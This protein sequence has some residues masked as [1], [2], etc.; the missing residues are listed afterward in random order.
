MMMEGLKKEDRV[1]LLHVQQDEGGH[2]GKFVLARTVSSP[3]V[4]GGDTLAVS[5]PDPEATTTTSLT[6]K[7]YSVAV[8]SKDVQLLED[9]LPRGMFLALKNPQKGKNKSLL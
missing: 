1:S 9:V 3:R 5:I 8:K 2:D 6:L 7:N 4:E